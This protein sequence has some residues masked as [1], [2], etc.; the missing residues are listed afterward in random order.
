MVTHAKNGAR[1]R[2]GG[3]G[4]FL[5]EW[6]AVIKEWEFVVHETKKKVFLRFLAVLF[7]VLTYFFY[8]AHKFGRREGLLVTMLT[9]S[10]FVF[11]TPIADAGI[12]I[13][14]PFRLLTKVR[15]L[16]SEMV[17]WVLAALINAYALLS[18]PSVYDTTIILNLFH[19][20]LTQPW[21]FWLIILLSAV[22]TFLSIIF[23]DELIDVAEERHRH[24]HHKHRLKLRIIIMI[25]VFAFILILYD[26]LLVRIGVQIPLL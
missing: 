24:L 21:P 18:R 20:I 6:H 8:V 12:L 10:F 23:A 14:F 26:F 17:V 4:F 16:Y 7:L 2:R 5:K 13:D 11:C 25:A 15:M 19:H 22:G 3:N 9:W 1:R